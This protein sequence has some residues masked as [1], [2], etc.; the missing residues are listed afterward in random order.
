METQDMHI[1]FTKYLNAAE[2]PE[3]DAILYQKAREAAESAYAP[4]S[5]F[6]VGAALLLDDGTIFAAN[7]QENIA[8]PSGLCAE[9]V[10]LFAVFSRFPDAKIHTIAIVAKHHDAWVAVSPC[11]ACRQVMSEC[12][13]RSGQKMRI[14]F[15]SQNDSVLLFHG[16]ESLL[17]FAF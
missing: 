15:T 11:G 4:Y 1:S 9:R 13:K 8:Y 2:L 16:I 5:N 7:N 6:Q 3:Q 14:L 10:A 12:E 17:P